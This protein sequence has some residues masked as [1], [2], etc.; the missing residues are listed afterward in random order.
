LVFVLCLVCSGCWKLGWYK[1]SA[2]LR[3]LLEKS[4][5]NTD[6]RSLFSDWS[7]III[8][9]GGGF[10]VSSS[11]IFAVLSVFSFWFDGWGCKRFK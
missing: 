2:K 1:S 5:I 4:V 6:C 7:I 9:R 11:H 10:A 8:R 3:H